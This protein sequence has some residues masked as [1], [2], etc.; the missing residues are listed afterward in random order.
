[1]TFFIHANWNPGKYMHVQKK[2][3]LSKYDNYLRFVYINFLGSEKIL[4]VFLIQLVVKNKNKF[5][6]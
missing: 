3:E 1:M 2:E 4:P 6:L 5:R